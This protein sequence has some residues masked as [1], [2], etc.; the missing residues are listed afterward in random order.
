MPE[1][2]DR[3]RR[4]QLLERAGEGGMGV[5]F[6]AR[7]TVLERDVALKFLTRFGHAG[8]DRVRRLRAEAKSL[9][10]LNHPDIVTL[11][12]LDEEQ[13]IPFL[14]IEWLAG[15]ALAVRPGATP[16]SVDG[17]IRIAAPIARALGAAHSKQVVHR[18]VKPG[19]ILLTADGRAKLGDFGLAR[20]HRGDPS[21]TRS[22][23]VLGTV[24]Y[25][26]PEQALG[27]DAGPASDV[28]SFG[29]TA[30]HLLAGRRPFERPS[31][32]AE[33]HALS[34]EAHEPLALRRPDLPAALTAVLDQCLRKDPRDR[35]G[36]GRQL[37]AALMSSRAG[38]SMAS[39]QTV[40]A[41]R[42]ESV[43]SQEVR[44]CTTAD[45]AS[46]AF[47]V[48][49]KGPPLVRV[50][51]W[52]THVEIEWNWPE[53][54]AFWERLAQDHTVVRY[55]GRGIGLSGPWPG[56]FTEETRRL[57]LEAVLA[58]AGIERTAL[59]GL[60]EGGWTA[61]RYAADFPDRVSHLILYGAYCRGALARPSF[62]PAEDDAL[63]MLMRKGWGQ[64][65]PRFRQLFTSAFFPGAVD[66]RVV[67][68]FDEM[69][70]T[71]ADGETAARYLQSCH[72]RGDGRDFFRRVR[73]PALV[74]HS[75]DDL[76]C[77][78]E[79]GRL[80]ASV[81]P[82]AEFLPLP[83]GTHYFPSDRHSLDAVVSAI[84]R[85]TRVTSLPSR[86]GSSA[87]REV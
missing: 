20:F 43:V 57:D 69:Q 25:M 26:A 39:S 17:F 62:D 6:R 40:S 47:A 61:A 8:P 7:D 27:H 52:F 73:A 24:G 59:L 42:V 28:F 78:F 37:E 48:I 18:D 13:G 11:Y 80:A 9:V 84:A 85:H 44:F 3:F 46:V 67:A 45:G 66:L 5:V 10:A 23:D 75:R 22:R 81:I 50:L 31:V 15:G 36:D 2:G 64:D 83:S 35:P 74:I 63:R 32:V 86:G 70:R 60:S 16:L 4:F 14:V 19:N 21:A 79:E 12:D 55:D 33:L 56:E 49:G 41:A 65:T 38:G 34:S 72:A 77:D 71:S 29:A 30:Y 53:M 54:R 87:A 1:V 82:G 51:G 68:H 58:A 76:V